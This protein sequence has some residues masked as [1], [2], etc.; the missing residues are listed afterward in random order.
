MSKNKEILQI[1]EIMSNEKGVDREVIFDAIEAALATATRKKHHDQINARVKINRDTGEYETFRIWE[2]IDD[3]AEVEDHEGWYMRLS[4]AQQ[5][6]PHIQVGDII[7]EPI[8][9]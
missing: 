3:D 1:V 9:S 2:V 4:E 5:R 6:D 8:E 7:E